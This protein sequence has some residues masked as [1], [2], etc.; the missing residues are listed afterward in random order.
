M[1]AMVFAIALVAEARAE[2]P[3]T[4]SQALE[5]AA[6]AN[7]SLGQARYAS[8]E[9]EAAVVGARATFDPTLGIDGSWWLA[10]QKGFLQ[11]FPYKSTSSGWDFGTSLQGTFSTGTTYSV[12]LG[13]DRSLSRYE[14]D[15]GGATS[16]TT[17][18]A[19]RSAIDL[20]VT[21][22]LLEG[23]RLAYNL[24]HV[25]RAR[26][27]VRTAELEVEQSR[28]QVLADTAAAYWS[29]VYYATLED[30]ADQAVLVAEEALRVGTVRVETGD[31]APV[32]QTRLE[33]A[34]VR[35]RA[36]AI[37]A[38]NTADAAADALLLLMGEV[39]GQEIIPA[40]EPGPT[41]ELDLDPAAVVEVALAQ[42]LDLAVARAQLD[43]AAET[44]RLSRHALLP[45]LSTTA[46]AGIGAQEE[47]FASAAAGVFRDGSYPFVSI[48]GEFAVPLGNRSA[49]SEV[50][51]AQAALH[52]FELEVVALEHSVA[53]DV[54]RQ[55]R[56]LE[57]AQR[58][59]ELA[60]ADVRLAEETLYAEEALA[61]AGR[62]IQKDV[63]EARTEVD[64]ARAE[65]A[66][67]RTDYQVAE[68]ELLRL[69]GQLDQ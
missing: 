3:I 61:S 9:A 23:H 4:Y 30:I 69:Q 11:G 21:Q 28:Q 15:F 24:Q 52:A 16:E 22:Q 57:S 65:A 20:A 43:E 60:D 34:L 5:G 26:R 37:E 8:V 32:E 41:R 25:T 46:A 38:Q 40:T 66:R 1:I 49:R 67:A 51:Q 42:N 63:L 18:D 31:L 12:E 13:M 2:R 39:P 45:S 35:A 14:T 59:I 55:V 17:Q 33:A 50:D 48:G 29:W 44:L 47:D 68:V 64:R 7:P 6:G 62:A 56:T 54:Q 10:N 36:D 27:A 58:R 53:A 19:Y